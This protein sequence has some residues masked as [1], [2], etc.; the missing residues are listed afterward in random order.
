VASAAELI[1]TLSALLFEY[2]ERHGQKKPSRIEM[3]ADVL[4]FL[5]DLREPK[6]KLEKSAGGYRFEGVPIVA[7]PEQHLPFILRP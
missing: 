5:E 6:V 4:R 7:K 2:R 1:E 3:S